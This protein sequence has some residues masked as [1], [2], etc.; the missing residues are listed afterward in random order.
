MGDN[1]E[2]REI[3]SI[4]PFYMLR[5]LS[6]VIATLFAALVSA[7]TLHLPSSMQGFSLGP[8]FEAYCSESDA[9][10]IEDLAAIKELE[11]TGDETLNFG[12]AAHPVWVQTSLYNAEDTAQSLFVEVTSTVLDQVD[13][14]YREQGK[15]WE[16]IPNGERVVQSMRDHHFINPLFY[17]NIPAQT[18]VDIVFACGDEGTVPFSARLWEYD[19]FPEHAYKE[20]AFYGIYYG[21]L[22]AMFIYNLVLFFVIRERVY[23]YYIS[24]VF[25]YA[26]FQFTDNGFTH[27]IFSDYFN[28]SDLNILITLFCHLFIIS[29]LM[30]SRTINQTQ[31]YAPRS[32]RALQLLMAVFGFLVVSNFL[33]PFD[34]VAKISVVAGFLVCFT[35]MLSA[36]IASSRGFKPARYFMIAF[37]LFF[38]GAALWALRNAGL[39]LP[40]FFADKAMQVGSAAEMMMLSMVLAYRINLIKQEKYE[41]EVLATKEYQAISENSPDAILRFTTDGDLIYSNSNISFLPCVDEDSNMISEHLQDIPD[42]FGKRLREVFARVV[43]GNRRETTIIEGDQVIEVRAQ[44]EL[45][46]HEEPVSVI[47]L[48]RDLTNEYRLR[49]ELRQTEKM[50]AVGQLAGGVAHDFNNQLTII[51]GFADILAAKLGLQ[52]SALQAVKKISMAARNSA[53]LTKQL[54]AFARKGAFY[55]EP[56]SLNHLVAQVLSLAKRSIDKN[57]KIIESLSTEECIID[58]DVAQLQNALLNLCINARDAMPEGGRLTLRT[59]CVGDTAQLRVI[60]TGCGID[61]AIKDKIYDP[62]FTTKEVGKGT[63]MGLAAVFG[64][65]EKHKAT[66]EVESEFG[67]GTTFI[68]TFPLSAKKPS[69]PEGKRVAIQRGQGHIMVIDDD[70]EVS[71][72]TTEMVRSLGYKVTCFND[73]EEALDWYTD[74]HR[75]VDIILLDMIMPD[76]DGLEAYKRIKCISAEAKVMIV[77]GYSVEGK[78]Q[79][80]LDLGAQGFI[81]KPFT[82]A[83]MSKALIK[84]IG[85]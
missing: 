81:Q 62:F 49:T 79:Q 50:Q 13:L 14:Y 24:Y 33:L 6:F 84:V 34:V 61:D 8:Y 43:E 51:M 15:E 55:I 2:D 4:I 26:I 68:L 74:Y 35:V 78:A 59:D 77:S 25:F 39:L 44:A 36:F 67:V 83:D 27:Y 10:T 53:S 56:I 76:M 80:V 37:G 9:F 60:D 7:K 38:S 75:E 71:A 72:L 85:A 19:Q 3:I 47:F 18:A 40:S 21:I 32:D 31:I 66:I 22:I 11:C 29:L 58:G 52:D 48:L 65:L 41:Q 16:C 69:D 20:M 82:A 46:I 28:H 70:E 42:D 30:F 23:L 45:G 1:I 63:G 57:I 64:T 73:P 5:L 54:L 12:F 17:L